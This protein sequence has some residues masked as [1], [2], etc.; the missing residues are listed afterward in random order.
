VGQ[1]LIV[2]FPGAEQPTLDEVGG[3]AASLIRLSEAGFTVP[4][5]AVLKSAFFAPWFDALK[6]TAT[7]TRLLAAAPEDWALLCDELKPCALALP[8]TSAQHD[9]LGAIRARVAPSGEALLAVRSSSPEEDLASA[10]FAGGYE[11]RLGVRPVDLEEAV[12]ACFASSLDLRVLVYK[13]EHGFDLWSP[14][15]AVVVQ[16]QIDSEAAGVGFSLNPVTNDHDEAVLAASWGLG[17]SV[18]E[19]RVSPDHYVVSKVERRV[20]EETRGD[21]RVSFWL[22]AEG[23]VVARDEDRPAQR[24]LNDAQIEELIDVL[25]R[26]E[27]LY[28]TPVDIEWAYEAGTLHVLQAR[29]ITAYVPLPAEM[30]TQ[31]GERRQLYADAALSKGMTMNKAISPLGL[32]N[33]E[34]NFLA[35]IGQWI[36][37]LKHGAA[38]GEAMI[39]FAGGRMY[40]NL[41]NLMWLT[42]AR[43]M[44]KS[45]APTDA[46][47]AQIL[48]GVDAKRYRAATRPSWVSLRLLGLVPRLFWGLR[49]FFW[50]MLRAILSPE[51]AYRRHQERVAAFVA[52]LD[53]KRGVDLPLEELRRT[54]E[55]RLAREFDFLMSALIVGMISPALLFSRRTPGASELLA[56][57]ELGVKGNVVVEMGIALHRLAR[58]LDRSA[59]EDL[60]RLAERIEQRRLSPAFLSAWDAFLSRYGCRGPLEMDLASPRYADDPSLAL[61]QMS[62]MA[63]EGGFD[64]E[65]ANERQVEERRRAQD[66]LMRRSGPL[67]RALLRRIY[68][69]SDLFAGTRDTPKYLTVRMGHAIRSRA[70]LEGRRL[71]QEGRLDEAEDVFELRFDD[72]RAA[73][74]DATLDL[75]QLR[76]ERARFRKKLELH[77]RSFPAVIDSRGRILRPPP[78]EHEPGLLVGMPVSAGVVT[79]PVKILRTPHEKCV[80]KGDVLVAYTTDPG[81]APLFVNAAAVVLEVGGTLQHGAVVAREYGKPCVVGIDRVVTTLRD[82]EPVEVDGTTGTVRRLS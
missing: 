67:R 22:G 80:E 21:K 26:I 17:T 27:A 9:A 7:W 42:S 11:T 29:P 43:M 81:W 15:I 48:A 76:E 33:I 79:G 70:L 72:L 10:S 19:G 53:E 68:R 20:L 1:A 38:P 73:A 30:L 65:A 55:L 49:G 61:R 31:P 82:G 45:S 56:K 3:K 74:E 58:L 8:L 34:H 23:G 2:P 78:V 16:R 60:P 12:R 46:L 64:P 32:D 18:V 5:G 41:S 39:F 35:I 28:G 44:A 69:L 54:F 62:F 71:V 63:V 36:G 24:T 25:G 13:Q 37:P 6:A 77:V 75:R 40:M 57:L 50:N 14:R 52:E 47:M 66:E 4:P 59:L 51:R